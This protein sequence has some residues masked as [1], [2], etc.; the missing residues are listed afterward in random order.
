[1]TAGKDTSGP[2]SSLSSFSDVEKPM[3]EMISLESSCLFDGDDSAP[4]S[5]TCISS[6]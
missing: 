4:V 6:S 2:G 1:M 5:R 3:D